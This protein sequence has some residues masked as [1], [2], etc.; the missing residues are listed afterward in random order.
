MNLDEW[1]RSRE[2]RLA[3]S[4]VPF[5]RRDV[6][7]FAQRTLDADKARLLAHPELELEDKQLRELDG[8]IQRR[9]A[10]EPVQY[11][12][13]KQEFWGISVK[14]GPGCLIPRPETEHLVETALSLIGDTPN[15]RV[16]EL[17]S[18]S[19][20][21]LL[22][23]AKERPDAVLI[24]IE[25]EE[26]ALKWTELNTAGIPSI[27]LLR[28]DFDSAPVLDGIDM[29]ISNPPYV[30]D[31][32][33]KELPLEIRQWEPSFSLRCGEKPLA[34]YRSVARWAAGALKAGGK[35]ACELGV[36]QARRASALRKIHPSMVWMKGL[37]DYSGKLRIA[38][39]Y[40]KT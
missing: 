36:A 22:A 6:L 9:K 11:I 32:E 17:G 24:G 16:V 15:P 33:W 10:R 40:M 14:V 18:G 31:K 2:K 7:I 38:C 28:G 3:A 4:G 34:P 23:L 20:C 19:G 8:F 30:S 37:R 12:L 21:V 29:V 25:K 13:G 1:L 5:P 27:H 26:E 35:F 39:W